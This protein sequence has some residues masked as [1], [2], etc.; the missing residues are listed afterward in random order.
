MEKKR[1]AFKRYLEDKR[2]MDSLS[3]IVVSLYENPE[4]PDDPLTFIRDFFAPDTGGVDIASI[5]QENAAMKK[6]LAGCLAKLAD[7]EKAASARKKAT[8]EAP[9]PD[10][11]S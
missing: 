5:R 11:A 9:S 1:E 7:L 2:V 4:R 8:E 3:R 6:K 10:S